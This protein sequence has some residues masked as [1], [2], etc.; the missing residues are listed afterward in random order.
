MNKPS[1]NPREPGSAACPAGDAAA[2]RREARRRLLKGG[3]A[4][5]PVALTVTSRPVLGAIEC[6]GPTGFQ[7]ANVSRLVG[8]A[9]DPACG[10]RKR[11][12]DW[13]AVGV[14]WPAGYTRAMLFGTAFPGTTLYAALTLEQVLA[15]PSTGTANDKLIAQLVV[16][17]LLNTASTT[18]PSATQVRAV[19]TG[20]LGN[21][22]RPGSEAIW[23][24]TKII[25]YL[26]YTM[27]IAVTFP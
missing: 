20:Y 4:A 14:S 1:E 9:A 19:W 15:G 8:Q 13:V 5:A 10:T 16:A 24:A 12:A 6:H 22:F 25:K 2:S 23:P 21:N 27:G 26:Q 17:A 3:L 11:P 7:S 18:V